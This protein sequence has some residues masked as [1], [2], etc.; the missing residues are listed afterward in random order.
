MLA[1]VRGD[2]VSWD[3]AVSCGSL[4]DGHIAI[5]KIKQ[6]LAKGNCFFMNYPG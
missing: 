1:K 3:I 4:S 2:C 5:H 6:R